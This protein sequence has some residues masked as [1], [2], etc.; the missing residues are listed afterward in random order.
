M[1]KFTQRFLEL[2]KILSKSVTLVKK[3]RQQAEDV[4]VNEGRTVAQRRG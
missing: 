3:L 2:F 4:E 1:Y